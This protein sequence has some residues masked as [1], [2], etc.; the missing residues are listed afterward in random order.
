[1]PARITPFAVTL[2]LLVACD[3]PNDYG[4]EHSGSA[5]TKRPAAPEPVQ[6]AAR[7]VGAA[8]RAE[9]DTAA[10][11]GFV[12][13]LLRCD[14]ARMN[15]ADKAKCR[16]ECEEPVSPAPAAASRPTAANDPDPVGSAVSCLQRCPPQDTHSNGCAEACKDIAA[17]SA[18]APSEA[19]LDELATCISSCRRDAHLGETNRATCELTCA[20]SARV[21]GPARTGYQILNAQ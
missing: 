20:E 15:R 1:M 9:G 13:C 18:V 5:A 19:V 21:A 6:P 16:Y 12:D 17:A 11:G 8:T 10:H 2:I 7:E 3:V 14:G 4:R